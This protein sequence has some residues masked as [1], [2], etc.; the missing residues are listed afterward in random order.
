LAVKHT[1]KNCFQ[2]YRSTEISVK[3]TLH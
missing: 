1:I 3:I 2:V